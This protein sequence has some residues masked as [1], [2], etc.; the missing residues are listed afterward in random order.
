MSGDWRV[1]PCR[2]AVSQLW[3]YL[4]GE[5]RGADAET[6]RE[7]L[8][9]CARCCPHTD[10]QRAYQRFLARTADMPVPP[11]LRRR[12]FEAILAEDAGSSAG[13]SAEGRGVRRPRWDVRAL[14]GRIFGRS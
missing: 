14:L 6:I 8:E 5:L 12:V 9:T 1:V 7:H 3:E 13:S 11:G 10:F 2:Q 4:D